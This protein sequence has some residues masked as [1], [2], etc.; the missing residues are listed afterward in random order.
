[1]ARAIN[2]SRHDQIYTAYEDRLQFDTS[3]PIAQKPGSLRKIVA[4]VQT[5]PGWHIPSFQQF[6]RGNEVN[7]KDSIVQFFVTQ[8]KG[9]QKT[10]RED[11]DAFRLGEE[12][13][14]VILPN[15]KRDMQTT[16]IGIDFCPSHRFFRSFR[17]KIR[18]PH[19]AAYISYTTTHENSYRQVS[20]DDKIKDFIRSQD[21][22]EVVTK[23]RRANPDKETELIKLS[24]QQYALEHVLSS[25]QRPDTLPL[26]FKYINSPSNISY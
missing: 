23:F 18:T 10:S 9:I 11:V 16:N 25:L 3:F 5:A 24:R 21:E 8:R 14:A 20:P 4:V 7:S 1:M 13:T 26:L 6:G 15:P 2:A 22:S 17:D 19:T 12:S